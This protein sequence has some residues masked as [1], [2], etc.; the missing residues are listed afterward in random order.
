M[1]KQVFTNDISNRSWGQKRRQLTREEGRGGKG[2]KTVLGLE[3]WLDWLVVLL[4]VWIRT[5]GQSRLAGDQ[6]TQK[7]GGIGMG[8]MTREGGCK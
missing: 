8:R 6:K 3:G 2:D 4:F 5:N 1:H 7:M